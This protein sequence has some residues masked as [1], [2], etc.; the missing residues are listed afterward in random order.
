MTVKGA[1]MD[2][3]VLPGKTIRGMTV[4][5][6]TG[7][8]GCPMVDCAKALSESVVTLRHTGNE[9]WDNWGRIVRVFGP[10]DLV[11]VTIRHD[12]NTIY[13]GSAGSTLFPGVHDFVD[14]QNFGEPA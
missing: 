4:R 12:R 10:G 1:Q 2:G 3:D 11:G 6:F 7:C 14:L 9:R 8:G 5:R 13:C